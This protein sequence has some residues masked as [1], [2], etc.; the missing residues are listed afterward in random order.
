[1][2][3]DFDYHYRVYLDKTIALIGTMAIKS[4]KAASDMNELV[5]RRRGRMPDSQDKNVM[6]ILLSFSW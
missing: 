1:M 3:Q 2:L 4:E 6:D 5:I